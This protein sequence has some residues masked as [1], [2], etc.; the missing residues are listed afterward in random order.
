M[1]N[2]LRMVACAE[3]EH[4]YEPL[5]PIQISPHSRPRDIPF[6]YLATGDPLTQDENAIERCVSQGEPRNLRQLDNLSNGM[7]LVYGQL[8]LYLKKTHLA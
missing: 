8:I 6:S 3:S 5:R 7:G 4:V 1:D 2:V